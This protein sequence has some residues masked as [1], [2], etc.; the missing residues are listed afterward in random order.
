MKQEYIDQITEIL[1]KLPAS[2]LRIVLIFLKHY[3]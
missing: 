1:K 2:K 3:F